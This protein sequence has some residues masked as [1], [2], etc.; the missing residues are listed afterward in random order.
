MIFNLD[1]NLMKLSQHVIDEHHGKMSLPYE[2]IRNEYIV[3]D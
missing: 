1:D 2:M 3:E